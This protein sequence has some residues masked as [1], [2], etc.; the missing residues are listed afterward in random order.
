MKRVKTIS[1]AV[2]EAVVT[3]QYR[4]LEQLANYTASES[5]AGCATANLSARAK[6]KKL[7]FHKNFLLCSRNEIYTPSPLQFNLLYFYTFVI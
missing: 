3:S 5:L 1:V 4:N 6:V 2:H 7:S